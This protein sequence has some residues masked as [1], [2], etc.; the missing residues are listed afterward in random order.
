MSTP[1]AATAATW[2]PTPLPAL[3]AAASY[4]TGAAGAAPF[5]AVLP[6]PGADATSASPDCAPTVPGGLPCTLLWLPG[7][8]QAPDNE[9]LRRLLNALHVAQR[10]PPPSQVGAAPLGAV[11]DAGTP[12]PYVAR[13]VAVPYDAAET[14]LKGLLAQAEAVQAS[15]REGA[16][17]SPAA[18]VDAPRAP[19][20]VAGAS[21]VV[22]LGGHSRGAGVAA[23]LAARFDVPAVLAGAGAGV[24]SVGG[25][26]RRCL[27]VLGEH[28]DGQRFLPKAFRGATEILEPSPPADAPP[29]VHTA[30]LSAADVAAAVQHREGEAA[31]RGVRRQPAPTH[32]WWRCVPLQ[33]DHSL[34]ARPAAVADKAA[35]NTT[36]A[37]RRCNAAVAGE[38]LRFLAAALPPPAAPPPLMVA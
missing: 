35:F 13:C 5:R 17:A 16:P 4:A 10:E 28:D 22:I 29:P 21:P 27:A 20:P 18:S 3:S 26:L 15:L 31:S 2:L 24:P 32:C 1:G 36:P 37:T 33:A 12:R 30:V 23:R 7:S 14:T 34:R 9:L 19:Q 11:A 8:G 25:P 6:A 38:V